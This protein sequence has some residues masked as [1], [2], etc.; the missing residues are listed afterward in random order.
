MAL[1]LFAANQQWSTRPD[2][3]RFWSLDDM[4]A[5]CKAYAAQAAHATVRMNQIGIDSTDE[6]D[7]C[8]VGPQGRAAKFTHWS[9]GQLAGRVSA[10]ADYLRRLPAPVAAQ[11]LNSGLERFGNDGASANV[12]FHANGD[13]ICRSFTSDDYARIWNWEVIDRLTNLAGQGWRVPPARPAHENQ[14]GA[15][16]ATD[17]DILPNQGDFGLRIKVGDQ[18]A[19]AGLYASDHDMFAFLVNEDVRIDDGSPNGLARGV[20]VMNSEVG[21]ASLKVVRFLYRHCC[22][23]HIVWDAKDVQ[24]LRIVHRGQND[25]RFGYQMIAELR[26]YADESTAGDVDRINSAKRFSLGDNKDEVLDRLFGLKILPKK[27]IESAY[28]K[29]IAEADY[30]T[31]VNPRSAWGIAQGITALS[32]NSVHADKRMELD[33]AAGRVMSIAF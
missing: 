17:A 8:I 31:H 12:L 33:R 18:I 7:L 26:R 30:R 9:F 5:Q 10:P 15:R 24:E 16:P 29:A 14:T 22:G 25:R 21:A 3:E 11:C 4:A 6:G 23:N 27:T 1:N 2:D 20:F 32:Q 19:P 13:L 28:E